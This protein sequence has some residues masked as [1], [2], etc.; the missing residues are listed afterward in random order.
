MS[1]GQFNCVSPLARIAKTTRIPSY[2]NIYG[3]CDIGEDCVIGA[4]VE[5]QPGVRI[6]NRVKVSS[7][8]FLCTGVTIEDDAFIGHGVMFVNDRYPRATREDGTPTTTANTQIYPV[9]IKRGAS[10]GTN[11]TVLAGVTIGEGALVGAGSVVTKDVEA[12][13]IV[14]GVPARVIRKRAS[15]ASSP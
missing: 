14:A 6:G 4:F 11:A 1:E 7:H 5:I 8:A 2:V 10:V 12:H 9:T 13:A 15:Q 3:E